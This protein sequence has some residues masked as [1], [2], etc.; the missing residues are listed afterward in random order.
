MVQ[1]TRYASVLAK[2]G[3]GR[4]QLLGES[5][6]KALTEAKN[7]ADFTAQLRET[8][9][10]KQ[11]TKIST[12]LTNQKI[13]RAFTENLIETYIKIIKYSPKKT[14]EFLRLYLLRFEI[15]N[16]K[17]LV[18]AANANLSPE[19]KASKI[20]F[21]AEAYLDQ[22]DVIE[23][24]AKSTDL[25]QTVNSFKATE[26]FSALKM[27]MGSFEEDGSTA[28]FDVLLDKHFYEKIYDEY[29][30]LPS[31]EQRHAN[32]YVSLEN[33]GFVLLTLLRGINLHYDPN[34][35]RLAVPSKRFNLTD[36]IVEGIVT[37]AD[38][39]S[40]LKTAQESDYAKFFVKASSPEET[41]SNARKAITRQLF[42][43]AKESRF[44]E[45][46]NIG[47]ILAFLT[48][49]QTEVQNLVAIS[50][51]VEAELKAEII[52]SQLLF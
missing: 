38:F 33:D 8:T 30:R 51:S 37:A 2:M 7:I 16:I 3:A 15:E 13:E 19:Q 46:F 44:T 24:A 42:L 5:K 36:Q 4:S 25:R 52:M 18:K 11:I 10:E 43:N 31:I 14:S 23:E 21:S 39:E 48:L 9:Y 28:C 26:Y 29:Q 27:G 22:L 40:A 20:Y 1:T 41:I 35:L 17:S 47:A 50:L 49:K 6:L 12:L 34:W 32:P 45:I